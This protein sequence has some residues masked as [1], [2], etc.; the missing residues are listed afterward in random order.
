M[1]TVAII[2]ARMAATRFP[3]K[4]MAVIRGMPMIGHCYLR[5]KMAASLREVYVATCDRAIFDYIRSIGGKAVMT[6]DT[7]ERASDRSAEA[8]LHI[9][10]ELGEKVDV[11]AMIQGDEPLVHPEMIERGIKPFQSEGTFKIVNLMAP[12]STAQRFEDANEV[13]VVFDVHGN[14]LYFSR[15]AIPSRKKFS[16]TVPMFKQLGMIFF[17]RDFL[18]EYSRLQPTPLEKIESVDMNRVLEHGEKIRMVSVEF[19]TIGV[20]VP[21]DLVRAEELMA[22]DPL[23]GKYG[24]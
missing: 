17:K 13:K 1:N 19:Q 20:D 12:I 2:P 16:G 14:A 6:A 10:H 23:V 9:E 21:S 8:L 11:V 22:K 3:G 18:L 4:P 7:H 24:R 5:T 15:E